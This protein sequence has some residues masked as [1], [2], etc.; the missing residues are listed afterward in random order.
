MTLTIPTVNYFKQDKLTHLKK[1]FLYQRSKN[2][3]NG[4]NFKKL[5]WKILINTVEQY[6]KRTF[7]ENKAVKSSN[8]SSKKEWSEK[9]KR[10]KK[11]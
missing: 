1:Y 7:R 6:S 2:H 11:G 10:M 8:Y 5:E 3:L 4:T 9:A